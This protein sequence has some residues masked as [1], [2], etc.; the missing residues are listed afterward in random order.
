[1]RVLHIVS[2]LSTGGAETLLMNLLREAKNE[3]IQFDFLQISKEKGFYEEEALSMQSNVYKIDPLRK[4]GLKKFLH[5]IDDVIKKNGPFDVIHSHV[6]HLSGFFMY[7]AKKNNIKVRISHCHNT[8]IEGFNNFSKKIMLEM[9]KYLINKYSTDFMACAKEAKKLLFTKNK[10]VLV[11]HNVINLEKFCFLDFNINEYKKT[12]G[13]KNQIV[14]GIIGRFVEQKNYCRGL[15][16]YKNYHEENDNSIL[17]LIGD[18]ILKEDVEEYA[19]ELGI[20]NSCIFLGQRSDVNYLMKMM[21]VLLMPSLFEGFP[22]TLIESQ[23]S[24]LKAIVSDTITKEVD[25]GMNLVY[26][27]NNNENW[28][29]TII[30]VLSEK[31]NILGSEERIKILKEN[32]F[33]VKSL[34]KFL[35]RVYGERLCQ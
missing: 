15:E 11:I 13:I 26:F 12:L 31:S 24:G 18:G 21:D 27:Q 1:M 19:K 25:L 28:N 29:K 20:Y 4:V 32:N 3:K 10:D 9:M 17:I 35:M 34:L 6:D 30:K 8:S 2:Q 23:A 5:N 7:I 14:F 22:L 16:I 33:D